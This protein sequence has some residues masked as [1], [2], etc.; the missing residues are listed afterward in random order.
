MFGAVGSVLGGIT[1][2]R[3]TRL[4]VDHDQVELRYRVSG[5]TGPVRLELE[6]FLRC[7]PW[8][9]LTSENPFLDG[10]LSQQADQA[11][12]A[13]ASAGFDHQMLPY[14]G[15]PAL[16][17]QLQGAPYSLVQH[18]SWYRYVY[19]PWE[20]ERGYAAHEDLFSPGR[21]V[22]ELA[23]DGENPLLV[24]LDHTVPLA[25]EPEYAVAPLF[26]AK[27][28]QATISFGMHTRAGEQTVLAGYPWFGAWGRDTL[29]ALPGLYLASGDFEQ[30]AGVLET[31]L[32]ARINGLVPNIPA[33]GGG[34]ANTSSVD[35]TLLFVRAVQ[36]LGER[37]GAAK[38][39]RFMPAV[40][41]LLE[42][43]AEA[44]DPRMRLDDGVGVFTQRGPW[45]LTWMDAMIDGQPVTPRAGYAVDVDALA[46]NAARFAQTW[47][48]ASQGPAARSFASSWALRLKDAEE[49]FVARYWRADR[50]YLADSH[51][52]GHADGALRPNQ[53]WALGLPYRAVSK[54]MARASLEAVTRE[55]LVPAGL[56]TLSPTD[57]AYQRHYRG[58]QA[59]RDRAYHQGTVW[60]WLLGIY[61]DAVRETLGRE[62]LEARLAPALTFFARHLEQEGCLGQV[63][64]VFDAEAPHKAHGTPAQAW[65][66]SE[67]YRVWH[68]LHEA[69]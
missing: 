62:A 2:E 31:M 4:A 27:L 51:D 54:E 45:A 22:V 48:S 41:D 61:A 8:H 37:A 25:Q 40:C 5:V 59:E 29:I 24:A 7:R 44:R 67:L 10:S 6:P 50:G 52:G 20:A 47:A 63:S 33:L 26:G 13:L 14:A 46:Y 42:A 36:W 43:L 15:M 60:P 39:A 32:A 11:K 35:A 56:R 49:R 57:R 12:L 19:Y 3:R 55:L 17:F 64:E 1:V 34:A 65:S 21:F 30:A 38:V 18:G 28:E 68:M 16:A 9:E 58:S 53:L 23:A 69:P 66:A